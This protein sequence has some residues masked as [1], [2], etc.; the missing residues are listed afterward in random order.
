MRVWNTL[1][2]SGR[3]GGRLSFLSLLTAAFLSLCWTGPVNGQGQAKEKIP[4]GRTPLMQAALAGDPA[5]VRTL[6]AEKP[7]VEQRDAQGRTALLLAVVGSYN[8]LGDT[9]QQGVENSHDEVVGLLLEAGAAI[10]TSDNSGMTPLMRA[11]GWRQ[12]VIL[13]RLLKSGARV[14]AVDRAGRT[15]LTWAARAGMRSPTVKELISRGVRIGVMEALLMNDRTKAL[16]LL[17]AGEAF[18]T[19][20]PYGESALMVAAEKADLPMVERLLKA[21]ADVNARDDAGATALLVVIAGR[22]RFSQPGGFVQWQENESAAREQIIQ[23][24]LKAGANPSLARKYRG[25]YVNQEGDASPLMRAVSLGRTRIVR[26]LLAAKPDLETRSEDGKTALHLAC[27]K[28]DA[29]IVGRLLDAG[30][31]PNAQ[32]KDGETPLMMAAA[33]GDLPVVKRLV[34]A[35]AKVETRSSSGGTA[36]EE[37]D[38]EAITLYLLAKGAK[39]V[40]DRD[41]ISALTLALWRGEESLLRPLRRAGAKIGLIEAVFM[42]DLGRLQRLLARGANPNM[43]GPNGQRALMFASERASP[44]IV[45]RLIQAGAALTAGDVLDQTALLHAAE[46]PRIEKVK[47][48]M[49]RWFGAG[50]MQRTVRVVE[51]L[52]AHGAKVDE[53]DRYPGNTALMYAADSGN[54]LLVRFLLSRGAKTTIKSEWGDET[55]LTLAQKGGHKRIVELLQNAK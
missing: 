28:G 45:E 38:G 37:A 10:D 55:A 48:Q 18:T 33:H 12:D 19:R 7:D 11:A 43:K 44:E 25:E 49:K 34:S 17:E 52:L 41:G 42:N 1:D 27:E 32:D 2:S 24:L 54:E 21:K 53:R 15:A 22:P 36:L 4:P 31:R 30:G 20:G 9:I 26:L 14:D 39:A 23:R 46:G 50:G 35:G 16:T 6:L 5:K 8:V 13:S 3:I 47:A 51:I 29:E 40:T